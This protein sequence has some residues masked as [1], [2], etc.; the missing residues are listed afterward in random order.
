MESRSF[1]FNY[2]IGKSLC[3]TSGYWIYTL[4]GTGGVGLEGEQYS[5]HIEN[6]LRAENGISLRVSYEVIETSPNVYR[7]DPS[8]RIINKAGA[9][10]YFNTP[11]YHTIKIGNHSLRYR[12]NH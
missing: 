3:Q 6:Q 1:P 9:S 7:A 10:I 2:D 4:R 8:T 5:T 11:Y 12:F